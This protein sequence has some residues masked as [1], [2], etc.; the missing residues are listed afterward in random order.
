MNISMPA[1]ARRLSPRLRAPSFSRLLRKGWESYVPVAVLA[2]VCAAAHAQSASP[3]PLA[4]ARVFPYSQMT[5]R[6]APNGAVGRNVFTGTMATGEAVGVHETMQPAGTRPN[7]PH[8]IQHSE[9][10][11]VEQGTVEFDHDGKA[12]RAGP[13]SILYVAYGTLHTVRN[14]GAGPAKYVVIQIGGDTQK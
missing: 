4:T 10:I 13:G 2:L 9:I 1:P 5:P 7:P 6:T 14:I 11:V 3:N 12:E 8:R